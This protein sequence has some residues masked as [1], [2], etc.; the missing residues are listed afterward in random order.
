M[1]IDNDEHLTDLRNAI[2]RVFPD[3]VFEG[4]ITRHDGAWLPEL[5]E[6]NAIHDDDMFLY[7]ALKGH[8]WSD[9]PCQLLYDMPG[10]FVL[11]TNEALIAFM[12]AWLLC[13]LENLTGQNDVREYFIYTFGQ[14]NEAQIKD[15]TINLLRAFNAEQ[16][17]VLRLLLMEFS[18]SE[19]SS[20]VRDHAHNAVK[21]I[22]SLSIDPE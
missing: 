5:T 1:S 6:E 7:E 20:F 14:E 3:V 17:A 10:A 15:F 22:E 9:I 18:K 12:G 16:L 13:S 8:K 11:L 2:L 4:K 21:L 19:S